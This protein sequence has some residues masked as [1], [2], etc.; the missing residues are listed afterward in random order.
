M[1]DCWNT[2]IKNWQIAN[3]QQYCRTTI[4]HWWKLGTGKPCLATYLACL[5]ASRRPGSESLKPCPSS[6]SCSDWVPLSRCMR[7]SG[8]STARFVVHLVAFHA[9]LPAAATL[10]DV[11]WTCNGTQVSYQSFLIWEDRG[12]L[13]FLSSK[14]HQWTTHSRQSGQTCNNLYIFHLLNIATTLFFWPLLQVSFGT[15]CEI[16][17]AMQ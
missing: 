6:S 16:V 12:L 8:A 4:S 5:K 11:R 10:S 1:H 13:P 7:W 3:G 2:R 14:Q 17:V 15:G 9:D